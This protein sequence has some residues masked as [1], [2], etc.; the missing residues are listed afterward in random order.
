ML[1]L[2]KTLNSGQRIDR[3][4]ILRE[5]RAMMS[6]LDRTWGFDPQTLKHAF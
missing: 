3:R 6:H 2:D 4:A 5:T 1:P